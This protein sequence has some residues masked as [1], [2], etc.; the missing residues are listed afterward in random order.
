MHIAF[1]SGPAHGH[2]NPAL[3]VVEELVER[4]H[5]VT[6]A[7]GAPLVGAVSESGAT[8]VEIPATLPPVLRTSNEMTADD[9]AGILEH[10]LEEMPG[11]LGTLE[12]HFAADVP[13]AVCFEIMT[14]E[15]QMLAY[16]LDVPAVSWIPTFAGNE[17]FSLFSRIV[18]ADFDHTSPRLLS[19]VERTAEM[20]SSNGVPQERDPIAAPPCGLNLSLLPREFQIAG[21]TFDDRVRFVGP[22]PRRNG[23]ERDWT[24]PDRDAAVLLVSLGTVANRRPDLFRSCVR[25]FAGGPWHVVVATGDLPADEIGEVPDNVELHEFVPQLSVLRYAS[26]FISHAGMN[27]VMEAMLHRVPVLAVPQTPE[28]RTNAA[29]VEELGLGRVVCEELDPPTLRRL[30]D[31]VVGDEVISRNLEWMREAITRSGGC[32]AAADAVEGYLSQEGERGE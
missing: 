5:R 10:S 8:P 2:V 18:S 25:V 13:D 19:A 15:G 26:A 14:N 28:Q 9:V 30:V 27:S 24:P 17:H 20:A 21:E 1:V 23:A 11:V 6:F 4:G 32:S 29:R 31:E 16:R 7:T 22:S 12:E 3:S